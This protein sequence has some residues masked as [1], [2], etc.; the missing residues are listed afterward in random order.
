MIAKSATGKHPKPLGTFTVVVV[1]AAIIIIIIVVA[2]ILMITVIEA[3]SI[4]AAAVIIITIIIIM[5]PLSSN[6]PYN[7]HLLFL[8]T[9]PFSTLRA[10]NKVVCCLS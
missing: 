5:A 4:V 1:A 6:I 7:H 3:V 9:F 8:Y 2:L 10:L